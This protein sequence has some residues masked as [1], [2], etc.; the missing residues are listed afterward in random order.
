MGV[1]KKH[2]GEWRSIE[3]ELILKNYKYLDEFKS[4]IKKKKYEQ[5]VNIQNDGSIHA[6]PQNCKKCWSC[7]NYP[8]AKC[9]A[10]TTGHL[11]KEIA[12]SYRKGQE[13]IIYDVCEFFSGKAY[14]NQSCGTHVHFD[15]RHV[16]RNIARAYGSRLACAVPALKQLI[17]RWRRSNEFCYDTINWLNDRGSDDPYNED[18]YAFINLLAYDKHQTIEV[19][20][21][22]GTLDADTILNWIEVCEIVMFTEKTVSSTT[23]KD[24]KKHYS[25]NKKLL[26]YIAK[27]VKSTKKLNFVET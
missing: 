27:R 3:F 2:L 22:A 25:L 5:F 1:P 13:N 12:V 9:Y 19:R 24:L 14:V 8:S 10:L 20:G 16:D 17:P 23:V 4:F 7:I 18:K 6:T 15:M 11:P 26:N 21:H